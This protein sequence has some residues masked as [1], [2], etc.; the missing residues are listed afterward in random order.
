[1]LLFASRLTANTWLRST[2]TTATFRPSLTIHPLDH[3]R[4]V[5]ERL[6]SAIGQSNRELIVGSHRSY[7]K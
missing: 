1:M 7:S 5:V 3:G 2:S 4:C 6:F